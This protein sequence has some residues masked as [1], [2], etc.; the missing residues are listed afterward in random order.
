MT[1]ER[2]GT[3]YFEEELRPASTTVLGGA[4]SGTRHAQIDK[5]RWMPSRTLID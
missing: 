3:V 5:G 2:N 4:V 1:G